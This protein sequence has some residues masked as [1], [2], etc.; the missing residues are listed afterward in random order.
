MAMDVKIRLALVAVV[1]VPAVIADL[2]LANAAE[3]RSQIWIGPANDS[4][5]MLD[6]FRKPELWSWARSRV[7]VFDFGPQQLCCEDQNRINS[8]R[9]LQEVN[10]FQM[11]NAWG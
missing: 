9:D 11:L 10:A 6:M 2:H 5:D 8:F 4:P 7:S 3:L 1:A